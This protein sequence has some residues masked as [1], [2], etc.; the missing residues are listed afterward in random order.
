[1]IAVQNAT[2]GAWVETAIGTG[3]VDDI[4]RLLHDA[5]AEAEKESSRYWT[6]PRLP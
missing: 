4:V 5:R 1:M 2:S 6:T 3:D